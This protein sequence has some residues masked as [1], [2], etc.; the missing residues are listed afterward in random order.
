MTHAITKPHALKRRSVAALGAL[1]LTLSLVGAG[2]AE[3]AAP[4]VCMKSADLENVLGKHKE[5]PAAIGVASNGSLLQVFTT[6][7]GATWSI[8]MTD[9]RGIS[10]IVAIGKDWDQR[11]EIALG[12]VS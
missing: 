1:A 6:A 11:A 9:P 2:P 8:V 12:E 5:A 4:N 10:C 3:A 7:D